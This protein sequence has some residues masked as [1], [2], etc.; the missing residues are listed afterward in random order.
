MRPDG[1]VVPSP[2]FD[3]DLCLLEVLKAKDVSLPV[4]NIQSP[5][6]CMA[7]CIDSEANRIV[8]PQLEQKATQHHDLTK[9]LLQ[10]A[11]IERDCK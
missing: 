8:L 6:C 1:I 4:T 7:M 11:S 5:V 2:G 3:H 10:K 9:T